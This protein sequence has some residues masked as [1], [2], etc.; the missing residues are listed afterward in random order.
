MTIDQIEAERVAFE[1][2]VTAVVGD[3]DFARYHAGSYVVESIADQWEAGS[4]V[5]NWP[6]SG[7]RRMRSVSW[8]RLEFR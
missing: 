2:A 6:T 3:F 8:K 7:R 1:A 4:P 5:P